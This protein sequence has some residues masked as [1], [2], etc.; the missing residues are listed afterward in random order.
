MTFVARSIPPSPPHSPDGHPLP[1]ESFE[2]SGVYPSVYNPVKMTGEEIHGGNQDGMVS[3]VS[4]HFCLPVLTFSSTTGL[5]NSTLPQVTLT[6]CQH[7]RYAELLYF[8]DAETNRD[9]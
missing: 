6:T 5:P 9:T 2:G 4:S 8:D 7:S 1:E 3:L